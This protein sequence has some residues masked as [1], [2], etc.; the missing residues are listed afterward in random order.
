VRRGALAM[1]LATLGIATVAAAAPWTTPAPVCTAIGVSTNVFRSRTLIDD[2]GCALLGRMAAPVRAVDQATVVY[3]RATCPDGTN[4][5]YP[6][7]I[8][9][10]GA[11]N[12]PDWSCWAS[13]PAGGVAVGPCAVCY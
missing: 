11:A 13:A 12:T 3:G 4:R 2:A 6:G 7:A 8:Y 5:V 1:G 9:A 10:F